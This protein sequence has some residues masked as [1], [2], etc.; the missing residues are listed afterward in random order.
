MNFA[1][2]ADLYTATMA[3]LLVM[4][5][6][7]SGV[8]LRSKANSVRANPDKC[9]GKGEHLQPCGLGVGWSVAEA[10][11]KPAGLEE[12]DRRRGAFVSFC[13]E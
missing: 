9:A 12:R 8:A 5:T 6:L 10:D 4:Q 13:Q 11:G 2:Q 7:L 3:F 1:D